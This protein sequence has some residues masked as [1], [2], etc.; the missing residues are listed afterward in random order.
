MKVVDKVKL[1]ERI[2]NL[3]RSQNNKERLEKSARILRKLFNLKSFRDAKNILF[4]ASF[5]GEVDTFDMMKKAKQLGKNI[6]L[7]RVDR[8]RKTMVPVLVQCLDTDL[9]VG[10]YGIKEPRPEISEL[11]KISDLDMVVV[12]GVAFD[13]KN[14][15][16]GRGGGYY[17]RFLRELPKEISTIGLAFDFQIIDSIPALEEHDMPVL[18]VLTN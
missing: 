1:R 2:L 7:P 6:F 9:R 10:T 15:R 17:D 13:R 8:S 12:P 14:N 5:D 16:L 11:E 18:Q 4:F 3:L